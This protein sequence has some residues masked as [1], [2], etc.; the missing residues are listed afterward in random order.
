[1]Y[2]AYQTAEK[3]GWPNEIVVENLKGKNQHSF[4]QCRG[5]MDIFWILYS[6]LNILFTCER[7]K[8]QQGNLPIYQHYYEMVVINEM[9]KLTG[10][11]QH[12]MGVHNKGIINILISKGV[13]D[14]KGYGIEYS[15][16]TC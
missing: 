15:S 16:Q 2:K 9:G 11:G 5:K 12:I 8:D 14:S 3:T 13:K 6:Q 7:A 1:M 4:K 10:F